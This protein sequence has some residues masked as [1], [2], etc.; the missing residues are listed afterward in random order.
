MKKELLFSITASDC[1]FDYYRGKGKGG[2]KKNVTD[3]CC[4]CTH[5]DSG[6]VGKSEQGRSQRKNKE[7]AFKKMAECAKFKA[8]HKIETSRRMGTLVDI[9]NKVDE[10]MKKIKVEGRLNGSWI[11]ITKV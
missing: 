3:N 7:M 10:E 1:R 5:E 8:W 6:A 2:Q 9:N 4:R 11:E